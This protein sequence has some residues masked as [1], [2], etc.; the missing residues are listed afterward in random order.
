MVLGITKSYSLQHCPAE[1]QQVRK[2]N[3]VRGLKQL[4]KDRDKKTAISDI[5][6]IIREC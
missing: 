2:C 3:G 5:E 6:M 1:E 4:L